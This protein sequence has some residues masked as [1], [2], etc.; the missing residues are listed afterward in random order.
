MLDFNYFFRVRYGEC[1][2][3]SV[4]FN[5]RYGDYVDITMTEYF[6]AFYGGFDQL[7]KQG[8]DT[9]VVNLNINWKSSAR[10]DDIVRASVTVQKVGNTSFTCQVLLF[11]HETDRLIVSADITYV[12]VDAEK[13]SKVSIPDSLKDAFSTPA[14]AVLINHAGVTLVD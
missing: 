6:R 12:C 2:A 5:A 4:V 8:V 10:F 11:H 1:D 14:Q 7:I 13:F 3:Q 9:Q